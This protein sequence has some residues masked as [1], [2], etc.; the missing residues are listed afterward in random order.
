ML[1]DE[2][3][4]GLDQVGVNRLINILQTWAKNREISMLVSSHQLANLEA[5]CNRYLFIDSGQL[6]NYSNTSERGDIIVFL[7]KDVQLPADL[8]EVKIND[9]PLITQIDDRIN[10]SKNTSAQLL[11]ELMKFLSAR[12]A[13]KSISTEQNS[14]KS[15]FNKKG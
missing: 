13:I 3:F 7:Q 11:N 14:L 4:V 6:V 2:P 9:K 15:Y 1:L 5:V 8:L 12:D 10:I